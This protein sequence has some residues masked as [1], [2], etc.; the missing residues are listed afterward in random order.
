MS[1]EYQ[2]PG[3]WINVSEK[4]LEG[5]AALFD[6]AVAWVR[7]FGE[8]IPLSYLNEKVAIPGGYWTV[9]QNTDQI[10]ARINELKDFLAVVA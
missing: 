7:G 8:A 1:W 2:G 10:I 9:K 6:S 4:T 3:V 5:E